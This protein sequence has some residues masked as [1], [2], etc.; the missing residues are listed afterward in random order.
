MTGLNDLVRFD[1]AALAALSKGLDADADDLN[2]I[3]GYVNRH[4]GV[5]GSFGYLLRSAAAQY[6]PAKSAICD[7]MRQVAAGGH[8]LADKVEYTNSLFQD[9][10]DLIEREINDTKIE[11]EK[12]CHSGGDSDGA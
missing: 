10:E 6:G 11:A 3:G 2:S 7:A 12:L 5:E 9:V 1:A 4:C 8:R